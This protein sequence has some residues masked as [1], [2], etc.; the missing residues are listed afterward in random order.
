[1]TLDFWSAFPIG[2]AGFRTLF[3]FI[4]GLAILVLRIA[5]YHVGRRTLT[6]GAQVLWTSLATL[7]TYETAFWYAFS[8]LGHALV[9]VWASPNSANL[10]WIVYTGGNRARLNE[11]PIFFMCYMG[12][13]AVFQTWAHYSMD[14][15]RLDLKMTKKEEDKDKPVEDGVSKMKPVLQL[16]PAIFSGTVLRAIYAL[17][18]AF[19]V[20]HVI[21][22]S[23]AWSWT[24][25]FF[26]PFYNL[27]KTNMAPP[28]WPSDLWLFGRC[29]YGGILVSMLWAVGNAAFTASMAKEPLKNGKALTSESKDPN[30]S[31]LN[32]LKSKKNTVKVSFSCQDTAT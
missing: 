24:L 3:I 23:L 10:R 6:P 1:M 4:C 30:G 18:T 13:L 17:P 14:M 5:H 19:A 22:R 12:V 32:G 8:S 2:P 20:Y 26:R 27:P 28:S 21:L 29:M 16:L 25:M 9:M 7:S 31:L 11:R 15:D